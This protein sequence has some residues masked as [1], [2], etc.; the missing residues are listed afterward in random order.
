MTGAAFDNTFPIATHL[1]ILELCRQCYIE[2]DPEPLAP[3][4][5]AA[6]TGVSVFSVRPCVSVLHKSGFLEKCSKD[7]RVPS[8]NGWPSYKMR[9]KR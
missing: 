7:Q 3:D 5:V 4:E 2:H 9:I 6:K 1:S 8:I